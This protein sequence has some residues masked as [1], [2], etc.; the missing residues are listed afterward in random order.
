MKTELK[1]YRVKAEYRVK[2]YEDVEAENEAE[3]EKIAQPL[4]DQSATYNLSCYDLS[5]D[6]M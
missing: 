3:A 1:K 6:E 4:L 5:V 2:V